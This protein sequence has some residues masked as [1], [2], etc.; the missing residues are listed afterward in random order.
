MAIAVKHIETPLLEMN[1]DGDFVCP[2]YDVEVEYDVGGDGITEPRG[3]WCVYCSDCEN[4]D[5]TDSQIEAYIDNAN[6]P[7]EE[8]LRY[9]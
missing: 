3:S 6:E 5:M 1:E 4:E 8:D 7:P 2:H 9:E